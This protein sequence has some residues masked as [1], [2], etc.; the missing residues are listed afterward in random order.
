MPQDAN[1]KALGP[2]HLD[3]E[4]WKEVVRGMG[5]RFNPEGVEPRAFTGWVRP[6]SV[7]GFTAAEVSSNA[8]RVE[9]TQRDVR[10][11]G[12]D[13]YITI[14]QVAG[15]STM[16]HNEQALQFDVGDVALVDVTRP[17]TFFAIEGPELWKSV[18]LLLPRRSLV[19]HLGFE[20]RGGL[21]RRGRTAAGRLLLDLIRN[22]QEGEGSACSCADS[23]MRLAV[24]DLVGALFAPLEAPPSRH[25]D[26]LFMRVRSTIKDGFAD[27]DFCPDEAASR[28]GISLRYLQK[29]FT[30]RGSTCSEFIFSLRLDQAARLL[31][32]RAELAASQPLSEIAY[33]CGFRDYAHFARKFRH[34][35][36]H[37]PG[38]CPTGD[39][40]ASSQPE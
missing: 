8:R 14:F 40:L 23:H 6:L 11:D 21:Y 5:G 2:P 38:A 36:G 33:T 30:Q 13:H 26:K 4:T 31:H 15:R 39:N 29:L 22:P 24:Y 19:S 37:A 17:A 18:A 32:R 16:T 3:F 34:R 1:E 12:A 35:F 25:A 9:R 7:C 27:P 10:L 20:P 28:V